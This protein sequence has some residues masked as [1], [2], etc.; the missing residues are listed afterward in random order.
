MPQIHRKQFLTFISFFILFFLTSSPSISFSFLFF[1]SPYTISTITRTKNSPNSIF[2]IRRF[3]SNFSIIFLQFN[4]SQHFCTSS[5]SETTHTHTRIDC[6]S[7]K[8][9][10]ARTHNTKNFLF[11][12]FKFLENLWRLQKKKT[13]DFSRKKNTSADQ[14]EI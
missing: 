5:F 11:S 6:I 2:A 13:L 12:F 8:Y 1:Y 3:D 10:D 4:P 7:R 14:N 9:D